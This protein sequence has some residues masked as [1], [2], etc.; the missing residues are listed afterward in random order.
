MTSSDKRTDATEIQE[1]QAV[2]GVD[3]PAGVDL[4]RVR[5]AIAP[6]LAAQGVVLADLAWQTDRMGWVLRITIEHPGSMEEGGGVTLEDCANVS[7]DASVVLDAE[8]FIHHHYHLEVS[9]PGLD[10][11]LYTEADFARFVGKLAKV[12]LSRPAPDGQR[13]L[14]GY[15]DTASGHVGGQAAV[16]VDGKRIEVPFADVAEANLVFELD[17]QPKKQAKKHPKSGARELQRAPKQ[18][19]ARAVPAGAR[20]PTPPGRSS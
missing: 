3:V 15:L 2:T 11:P 9:S 13:V 17:A 14:R 16:I 8:D 18:A 7:R 19:A 20:A 12:R 6:V 10:R 1:E 4:S 5:S